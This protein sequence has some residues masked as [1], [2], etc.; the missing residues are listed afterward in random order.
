MTTPELAASPPDPQPLTADAGAPG[1]P[2]PVAW[3]V[4]SAADVLDRLGVAGTTGLKAAEAAARQRAGGPN[5]IVQ[6]GVKHPL[7]IVWEQLTGT[8]VLIL[9]AA[10]GVSAA[11]GDAKD[12]VAILA[13]IVLNAVLG[14]AQEHRAERAMAALKQLA[15]PVVRVR[16]DGEVA[17][18]PAAE[19]VRGDI[20][21]LDA[22]GAVPADGRLLAAANLRVQEAILTGE[23]E[24]VQ[25]QTAA[26]GAP[27]LP[28]GDRLNMAFMGTVVSHGRGEMVVT[29]IGM[30]T[31]L[32]RVADLIQTVGEVETPLQRRL[33][34]L[35]RWLA[36]V[37]LALV[38]VVFGAG[39]AI[40][41]DAG[42]M[43]MTAI[44]MA[45]AVVPEGLP[46]VV[47]I[48]LALGAQRMLRRRALIRKLPAV[49]TLGSVTV[50]CT[51]K[52]G[53]LTENR[54]TV[55]ILD[56]ADQ[57]LDM[58]EAF[59]HGDP[60]YLPAGARTAPLDDRP[61]LALL[62]SGGA[63]CNDVV[64]RPSGTADAA[65]HAVGD[66][67]EGALA[68]AAAR[69]GVWKPDLDRR[70]PRVTE[71]PF[72]SGRKRMTTVHATT[73]G[74]EAPG[75]GAPAGTADPLA[76]LVLAAPYVAF[77]KGAVDGL[78]DV[79]R[80]VW[81]GGRRMSLGTAWR[82]RILASNAELAAKGMRVL[83]VA[84][85]PLDAAPAADGVEEVE[86]D[87]TFIGLVAMIDPPRP[88]VKDA[89]ATCTTAGIRTVM[90]TGDH[91][92]TAREIGRT[93]GIGGGRV[94]TGVEIDAMG[95]ADLETLVDDVSVFARVSP[96]HKLA[97]VAALQRRGHVVAMTGDGVNDAPA[98][99]R[100]DIGVAMG[101]TGTDVAK[102][103]AEMVLLDD[104]FTT[105]VAAVE[106][107][108]AIYDNI[109]KFI[110]FSL[111]GNL[112]KIL[113]VVL[114]P[115]A[116]LPLPFTPFQILWMNLVTDGVLGLGMSVE[117]AEA[118]AMRRPPHRPDE[119]VFARG[120]ASAIT[121]VGVLIGGI[122]LAVMVG[123]WSAGL[124]EWQTMGLSTMIFAQGFQALAF[125]SASDSLRR[126][127]L[128]S[129]PALLAAVVAI[130][131]LQLAVVYVPA[132]Q[133]WFGTLPLSP[134][135]LAVTVAAASGVLWAAE[136]DKAWRRRRRT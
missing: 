46:A 135:Q 78:L 80:H 10:A 90:I 21:V 1:R 105:I 57:R 109:R 108:R 35:G 67:T 48:T 98:L 60:V 37:A 4:L 2:S 6:R 56:L 115:L 91:P 100:A 55:T 76:P 87:L 63:L 38:V 9:V 81:V 96:E 17:T 39:I 95:A 75:G 20:V 34:A 25:K 118:G 7:R 122:G 19:L 93:L 42:L 71:A 62:L 44:S 107:G 15:A 133:G 73:A 69:F 61:D 92:L 99:K 41:E 111:A 113:V 27:D 131:G 51:D 121:W 127:G 124:P 12:A 3:H 128:A 18:V 132:L 97:I 11:I 120:L 13:I 129:N 32:G 66:P 103:A 112:G 101:I 45:V 74:A 36:M 88:E 94:V 126:I 89:I 30:D 84:F 68:V 28:V 134:A 5:Q 130:A 33:G 29:A 85:R 119:G 31:E 72:D 83:G 136:I 102:E 110:Q 24:P 53:T 64:L 26:L 116:G 82:A 22:G 106:E 117:P 86:T 50:I 52:T 65:Y 58:T 79:A 70:L 125:R 14:F 54:M 77:T 123:A 47:T 43:L 23:S 59:R 104:N 49:E 8:L 40:G 16:R 114:G